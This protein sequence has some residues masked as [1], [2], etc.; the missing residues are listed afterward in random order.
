MMARAADPIDRA[1]HLRVFQRAVR[2]NVSLETAR[3]RIA[4]E[5]E[6]RA[7]ERMAA[8]TRLCGTALPAS[9]EASSDRDEK[10][11]QWWQ[12]W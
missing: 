8:R 1:A 5:A 9:A 2:D 11:Q 4:Q 12:Q 7:R 6:D 3:C 10:P